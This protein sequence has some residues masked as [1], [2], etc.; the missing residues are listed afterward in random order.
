MKSKRISE[1]ASP[2]GTRTVSERKADGCDPRQSRDDQ[3]LPVRH[4]RQRQAFPRRLQDGEDPL[5]PEKARD[6]PHCDGAVSLHDVDFMVKDSKRFADSG[7]WGWA[8]FVN[9]NSPKPVPTWIRSL[10]RCNS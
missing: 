8:A 5:E 10:E 6:V 9:G 2:F 3:R 1:N 4:S 7:G